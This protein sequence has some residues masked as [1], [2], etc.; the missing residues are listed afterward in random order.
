MLVGL[1]SP[2]VCAAASDARVY[3]ELE[4]FLSLCM[5]EWDSV[6]GRRC[7]SK[8]Y[9]IDKVVSERKKRTRQQSLEAS[10]FAVL[11][12][13][14]AKKK[15]EEEEVGEHAQAEGGS[16]SSKLANVKDIKTSTPACSCQAQ[17]VKQSNLASWATKITS[18][19]GQRRDE[20][21]E[22]VKKAR[23]ERKKKKDK[24][25]KKKKRKPED[26]AIRAEARWQ[27]RA[28]RQDMKQ[29]TGKAKSSALQNQEVDANARSDLLRIK[30][31]QIKN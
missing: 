5:K 13:V 11:A 25:K 29:Q 9:N 24:E 19:A 26:K 31:K 15:K 8:L 12:T 20:H 2:S 28:E 4:A 16:V 23:K 18:D 22:K 21:T 14:K 6:K 27:D 3:E 1:H 17:T 7:R 10:S 30:Q